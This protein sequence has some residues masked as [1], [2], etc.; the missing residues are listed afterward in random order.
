MKSEIRVIGGPAG[1]EN[2]IS[3]T[4][5]LYVDWGRSSYAFVIPFLGCM[6]KS[7]ATTAAANSEDAIDSKYNVIA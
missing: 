7:E 5:T 3:S 2:N 4:A 1:L 6:T